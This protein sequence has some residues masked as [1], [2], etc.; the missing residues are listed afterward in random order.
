M[1]VAEHFILERAAMPDVSPLPWHFGRLSG[2]GLRCSTQWVSPTKL[3]HNMI[4]KP[5]WVPI[6][7]VFVLAVSA[8]VPGFAQTS[9]ANTT[10]AAVPAA[11]AHPHYMEALTDLRLAR[12]LL[13]VPDDS[14]AAKFNATAVDDIDQAMAE[15]K[16]ASIDDGKSPDDHAPIDANVSRRDRLH[17]VLS[18]VNGADQD[19]KAEED[20]K[21]ALGWRAKAQKDVAD[22]RAFVEASINNEGKK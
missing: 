5:S 21:K 12:A 13:K 14:K 17:E 3:V 16:H 6:A 19:L 15:I 9:S 2:L 7:S 8:A 11:G 1:A 20:D 10:G 4:R 22:A 18:L